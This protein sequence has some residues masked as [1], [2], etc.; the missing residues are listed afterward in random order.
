MIM[1]CYELVDIVCERK[2][3]P[4]KHDNK[5]ISNII[6]VRGMFGSMIW[7]TIEQRNTLHNFF[8]RPNYKNSDHLGVLAFMFLL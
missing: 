3:I 5:T 4:N 2:H 1:C 6:S 8:V 7:K